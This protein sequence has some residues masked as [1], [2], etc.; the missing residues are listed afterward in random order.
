MLQRHNIITVEQTGFA[1]ENTHAGRKTNQTGENKKP[2]KGHTRIHCGAAEWA[3]IIL[4]TRRDTSDTH[5]E[6]ARGGEALAL[7]QK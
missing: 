5:T 6:R 7:L 3:S 1:R 2:T 4:A